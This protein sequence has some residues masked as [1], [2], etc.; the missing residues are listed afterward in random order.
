MAFINGLIM[1]EEANATTITGQVSFIYYGR[2]LPPT[3]LILYMF[4][5]HPCLKDSSIRIAPA[6]V[7]HR[8]YEGQFLYQCLHFCLSSLP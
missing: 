6:F 4:M 3:L 7:L 8:H 1:N 5:L 2:Y